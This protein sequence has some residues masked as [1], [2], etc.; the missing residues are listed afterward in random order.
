MGVVHEECAGRGAGTGGEHEVGHRLEEAAARLGA[1]EGRGGRKVGGPDEG[2][3]QPGD[4]G[5]LFGKQ[6]RE[7]ADALERSHRLAQQY[8]HR[9]IREAGLALVTGS[10]QND[11]TGSAHGAEQIL[12]EA[13]LTDAGRC[14]T[15]LSKGC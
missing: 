7:R 3:R 5:E 4:L 9:S 14:R 10:D 15:L 12:G 13:G 6:L 1:G 2:G 11:P 8:R